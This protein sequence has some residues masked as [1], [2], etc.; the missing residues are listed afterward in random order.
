MKFTYH[1]LVVSNNLAEECCCYMHDIL[2]QNTCG[3]PYCIIIC[4]SM[5]CLFVTYTGKVR[6]AEHSCVLTQL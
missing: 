1:I 3:M 2:T 4:V 5:L 6:S